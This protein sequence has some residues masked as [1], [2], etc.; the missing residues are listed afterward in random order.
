[1]STDPKDYPDGH[2]LKAF[3]TEFA[4]LRKPS[5]LSQVAPGDDE[6]K[7]LRKFRLESAQLQLEA[8]SNLLL[9]GSARGTIDLVYESLERYTE[10]ELAL[11][12]KPESRISIWQRTIILAKGMEFVNKTRF[13]SG[14]I[15]IQDYETSRYKRLDAEI[16][17]MELK[18]SLAAPKA[19]K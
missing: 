16:K 3:F 19:G 15:P 10:S 12:D 14:Q 6:L 18:Q 4:L 2:P 11:A 9:A 1:M 5:T 8:R 7:K 17:L 13:D